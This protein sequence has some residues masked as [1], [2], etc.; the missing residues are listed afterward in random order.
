MKQAEAKARERVRRVE[1]KLLQT[2]R[3]AYFDFETLGDYLFDVQKY[4]LHFSFEAPTLRQNC[5]VKPVPP[6]TL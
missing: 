5:Y 4:I 6:Q 2:P 1:K 3:F